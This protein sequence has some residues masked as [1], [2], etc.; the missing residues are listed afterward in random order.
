MTIKVGIDEYNEIW[1]GKIQDIR[2]RKG[3]GTY[4]NY[5]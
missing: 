2:F 1:A 4:T 3:V 5:Q